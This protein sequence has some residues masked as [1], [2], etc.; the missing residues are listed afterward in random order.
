MGPSGC[1]KPTLLHMLGGLDRADQRGD[2][3]RSPPTAIRVSS[4][5]REGLVP[6]EGKGVEYGA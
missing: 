5:Y 6:R 2:P 1:G 4:R 3:A